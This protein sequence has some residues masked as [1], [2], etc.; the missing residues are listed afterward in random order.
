MRS[1]GRDANFMIS[2]WLREVATALGKVGMTDSKNGADIRQVYG[3]LTQFKQAAQQVETPGPP[4]TMKPT[5]T[6]KAEVKNP[7]SMELKR[8]QFHYILAHS[9]HGQTTTATLEAQRER[10]CSI[11][12]WT[13]PKKK[14]Q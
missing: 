14:K 13:N 9:L 8:A 4:G 6:S 2:D 1:Q 10:L 7:D 3:L 11:L 5:G 12:Y